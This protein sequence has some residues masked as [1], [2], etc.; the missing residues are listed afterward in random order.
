MKTS[1][2]SSTPIVDE[3]NHEPKFKRKKPIIETANDLASS[4]SESENGIVFATDS[5]QALNPENFASSTRVVQT[6]GCAPVIDC[7]AGGGGDKIVKALSTSTVTS[8]RNLFKKSMKR[9][10]TDGK[11]LGLST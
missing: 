7:I 2:P 8:S 1:P 4:F 9:R 6:E 5:V 10:R 3:D 11:V